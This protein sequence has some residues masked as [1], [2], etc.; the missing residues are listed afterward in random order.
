MGSKGSVRM[1]VIETST[2]VILY[3][4]VALDDAAKAQIAGLGP[5]RTIIAPNLFHYMSLRA[6]IAAYPDA[7]VY[8]PE[9]LAERIGPVD[10]AVVIGPNAPLDLGPDIEPFTFSG[11]AIHETALYHRP[12][13]T[14]ITADLIYHYTRDQRPVERAMFWLIGCYG[15][16]KIAFY[17]RFAIRSKASVR[18]LIDQV[19]GWDVQRIVMCHGRIYEGEDAGRVFA[20]AWRR[21][22]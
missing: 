14:L 17:H 12:S 5:V 6:G 22:G 1:V 11:H 2:G 15:A 19:S 21:M 18:E 9:G 20:Q 16:P 7:A 4:P 8:V 10:R 13:K 3:S